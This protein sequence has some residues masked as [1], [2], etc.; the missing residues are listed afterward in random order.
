MALPNE[1]RIDA[2]EVATAGLNPAEL[3]VLNGVTGGTVTASKAVVVDA[4]KD[5]SSFNDVGLVNLDAGS[6]GITGSVDV[7]PASAASGKLSLAAADN[8]GDYTVTITN[9]SHFQNTAITIPDSFLATSYLLQSTT[10]IT[11]AEADI[12][13]GLT[14]TTDMINNAADIYSRIEYLAISGAVTAG[15]QSVELN[16]D[17]T[18]IAATIAAFTDHQGIFIVKNTSSGGIIAHNLTL[19]SGTFDGTNT[20]ATLNAPGEALTVYVDSV[21][22]GVILENTGA[23]VLS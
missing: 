7:F 13:S 3:A 20:I 6:S 22:N 21:G 23:V 14:A 11:A 2:L 4:S 16:D 1:R 9:A 12:L 15:K 18:I 19:T 8:S 10:A 5:I 17:T